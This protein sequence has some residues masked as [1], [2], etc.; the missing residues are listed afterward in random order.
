MRERE[1]PT[2]SPVWHRVARM[3]P[4][5]RSHVQIT[6][7]HYRGRRWH[8][9][10][11]PTSNQ[12]YRLS[13]VAY[14]MVG[15]LD[16]ARTVE[17]VWTHALERHG[18]AAP[19][20]NEVVELLGQL[21]SSNLL[22]VE[23]TPDVEQ[24]LTRSNKRL[25]GQVIQ[26]A[27]GIMYFKIR[28]FN[29]D[30]IL[31]KLEPVF[32]P[33][34]GQTGFVF[35]LVW[36]L[37]AIYP[38]LTN[39][40]SF[41]TGFDSAI[42]P[43]NWFWLSIVFVITKIIHETGHGV[44]CKRYGGLVPE[45]GVMILVLFPSPYVDASSCWAFPSKWKRMAVGA[46]GMIFELAI[47]AGAAWVWAM[48][49]RGDESTG[50]VNQIAYNIVF[51]SSISTVLFNANPLMKFDGYYI[52]SDLLEVPN[53]MQRSQQMIQ[54]LIKKHAYRLKDDRPPSTVP[55]ERRI[56]VVFGIL[57]LLYRVFLF[58]SITL[59]VMGKMFGLGVVLAVWTMASWFIFPAGKFIHW[60]SSSPQL[61][62]HRMR[63][64]GTSLVIGAL[65]ITV[66]GIIPMP[67]ARYANGIVESKHRSGVFF[68]SRNGFVT[69]VFVEPG[70]W[71]EAGQVLLVCESPQL[72]SEIASAE[73]SLAERQSIT[74]SIATRS[75][76][77]IDVAQTYIDAINQQ[78]DTLYRLREKLVVRAP[79]AGRVIGPDPGRLLGSYLSQGDH[80]CE[81][82]DTENVQVAADM[83]TAQ[84]LPVLD[85]RI[86]EGQIN[87]SVRRLADVSSSVRTTDVT[88][89]EGGTR[90]LSHAALGYA[91]GGDIEIDQTQES[92]L[93]SRR[94][95]FVV[96]LQLPEDTD[97]TF[98]VP[99]E[100][101]RVRFALE[102][103]P[104]IAQWA[105]RLRRLVQGRAQL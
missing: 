41:S 35:W 19:T 63:G 1:R 62:D 2:F 60:L 15:L 25:K 87:A 78:L 32:R 68:G 22:R 94:P 48:T 34:I 47:A 21:Y 67:D 26:K 37:A 3:T 27:L 74:R 100:R 57:S 39:F 91:G 83:S 33:L 12:F 24:L 43:S 14:E 44:I 66:L 23:D 4:T 102:P 70:Q 64:L 88:F 79:H 92:G 82:V 95:H 55:S 96:E 53:L 98:G 40:D 45:T 28:L 86:E 29:P 9:V 85:H 10:H 16:G 51:I 17:E 46:G 71:V 103:K 30:W 38:L 36:V 50:L 105:D 93:V 101:V 5:L 77:A 7:Q 65:G 73:G 31:E 49:L 69:E 56:L 20:Q 97:A 13:P 61:A 89:V 99:G 58:V 52:L 42:A 90:Q 72:L 11:D 54:H 59:F 18:D 6:R 76:A 84:W 80:I 104:L 75:A 8:V 81:V